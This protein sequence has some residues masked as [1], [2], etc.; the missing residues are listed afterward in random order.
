MSK[1][2]QYKKAFIDMIKCFYTDERMN[3]F[4]EIMI[5]KVAEIEEMTTFDIR[6]HIEDE[7]IKE[8][9]K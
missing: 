2:K 8:A 4:A 3:G 9:N 6:N 7:L 5:Q 1:G